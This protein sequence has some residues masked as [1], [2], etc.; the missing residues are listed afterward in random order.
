M[1]AQMRA[2][3]ARAQSDMKSV[4]TA[5]EQLRLDKGVFCRSISG[6]MIYPKESN[7]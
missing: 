1:N 6:V 5:I 2:K 7:E 4:I 3:I